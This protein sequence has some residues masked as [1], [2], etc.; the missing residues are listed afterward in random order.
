MG[1]CPVANSTGHQDGPPS[2]SGRGMAFAEV[3][4]FQA[5][6]MVHQA[7]IRLDGAADP[8]S[9]AGRMRGRVVGAWHGPCPQA[10]A[11]YVATYSRRDR[12]KRSRGATSAPTGRARS[13]EPQQP[14]QMAAAVLRFADPLGLEGSG[15]WVQMVGFR[16][17]LVTKSRRY[18]TLGALR[19]ARAFYL[20]RTRRHTTAA[21][22]VDDDASAVAL[23]A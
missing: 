22:E 7:I 23:A 12:A 9:G 2:A 14:M 11:A 16:A 21:G 8:A 3:A 13:G 10:V 19:D 17:Q 15:R 6:G 5:R 18:T 20:R 1:A 4:E